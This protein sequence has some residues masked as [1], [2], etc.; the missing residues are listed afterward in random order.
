MSSRRGEIHP[1]LIVGVSV[2]VLGGLA[3]LLWAPWNR[4]NIENKRK[5][6]FY[7]AAGMIGPVEEIAKEYEKKYGVEIQID[8]DGTGALLSKIRSVEGKGD[9]YLAADKYHMEKAQ[10]DGWVAETIPIGYLRPVLAISKKKQGELQD[11]GKPITKL[12]DLLREDI[13]VVMANPELAAIGLLAKEVME[14][15]EVDL[16][17]DLAKELGDSSARVSTVGTVNKVIQAVRTQKDVVGIV[18]KAV[19]KKHQDVEIIK[20]PEFD[21]AKELMQIGILAKAD[22]DQARAAL[23]FARFLTA[24]D[25]GLNTFEKY[26]FD[27]VPDGDVWEE[28]PQLHLSAG[29]M[30]K[31]GIEKVVEAFEKREGVEIITTYEGCGILVSQMKAI[32]K[33][34]K[35]THFP[36]AYFSCD[37][38]FLEDVKDWFDAGVVVSKNDMVIIVQKGNPK[39]IQSLADLAKPDIKVGLCHPDKSA[40]G[41]LADDLFKAYP[42]LA[43]GENL[44]D[45]LFAPGWEK[46]I[47]KNSSAGHDLVNKVRLKAMDAAI[48][49]RS[50]AQANPDNINNHI[51]IVEI[52]VAE[53]IRQAIQ[54]YAIAKDSEHKYLMQRLLRAIVAQQTQ[55][56]FE[57]L[58]FHWAY[59]PSNQ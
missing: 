50:N 27:T 24:H 49:Y 31:P 18:W 52:N 44:Y 28:S 9:L 36:D 2:L 33:G 14:S 21:D 25:K 17:D 58:G 45:K 20:V 26:N 23:Q 7:S 57:T 40:L 19:A 10:K 32:K 4:T 12:K 41:K 6:V 42:P 54:P 56:R 46:H 22:D 5:L 51:D 30:L 1:L 8:A 38:S 47:F 16:W 59:G 3:L 29:A 11:Q 43:D 37:T 15:E 13:K 34:E 35:A 55:Q 53:K 39:N 48:V